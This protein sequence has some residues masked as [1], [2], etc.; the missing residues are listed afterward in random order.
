MVVTNLTMK[1]FEQGL[2]TTRSVI[3]PFGSIEEHGM[4]LPLGTDTFHAFELARKTSELIPVFVMPP[5]WYGL[6]RSTSRHPGTL[7]ITSPSLRMLVMDMCRS[8]YGQ[9]LRNFILISGH[10]GGTHM[11]TILD[12]ADM[13]L[14]EL[15]EARFAVLSILDLVAQLPEGLVETPGD[16]HAGEVETSLME[17]LKPDLV[18]G[19]SPREF[20]KFPKFILVRDKLKYWPGGVWGDPSKSSPLKGRRILEKEADLLAGIVRKLEHFNEEKT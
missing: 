1:A 19:E 5:V 17:F 12:A 9:G 20:P 14:E 2:S 4:H 10:A 3:V 11:S 18:R 6:C 15:A 16:A 8:M 7:S 13:L